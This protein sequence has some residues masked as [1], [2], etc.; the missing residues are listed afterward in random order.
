MFQGYSIYADKHVESHMCVISGFHRETM[1][2]STVRD[3]YSSDSCE[4]VRPG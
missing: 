3:R 2:Y 4:F 1:V